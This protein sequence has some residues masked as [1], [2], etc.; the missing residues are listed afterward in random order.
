MKPDIE[1]SDYQAAPAELRVKIYAD[2]A[3][4]SSIAASESPPISTKSGSRKSEQGD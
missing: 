2:R 1:F 4:V 3:A